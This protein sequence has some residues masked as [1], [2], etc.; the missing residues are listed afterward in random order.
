MDAFASL[1]FRPKVELLVKEGHDAFLSRRALAFADGNLEDARAILV[2]DEMDAEREK[3]EEEAKSKESPASP[4]VDDDVLAQLRKEKEEKQKEEK[5]QPP[6]SEFKTVSVN[7]DFDPTAGGISQPAPAPQNPGGVPPPA[8]KS[9]VVFE[10]TAAQI[11]ELV[12]ESPVP[13]LVDVYADWCGPCKHLTPL[14]EEMAVKAGGAFRLVK[15]NTDNE[16]AVSGALEVKALPTVFAVRNGRVL[17][18]FEGMP[19]S[20]EMMKGF[21]MGLL[22]E[23]ADFTPPLSADDKKRYAELTSK[24]VKTAG[25]ASFTFAARERLQD[26]MSK[27][28]QELVKAYD[29]NMLDA[30]DSANTLR[31]LFSNVIRKPDDAKYRRVNLQNKVIAAKI[32][33]F[34]P[35]ISMLKYVG[36]VK[37]ADGSAM[38]IGK[39]KKVVNVAPLTVARDAIDKWIDRNRHTLAAAARKRKDEKERARLAAEAA[40]NPPE[41][42]DED[43]EVEVDPDAVTLKVRLEGKKKVHELALHADDPLQA[44]LDAL[45]I[46][47]DQ[48]GVQIVCASK[49]LV[50]KASDAGAMAKTLREHK[51]V[52]AA[53]LVIKLGNVVEREASSS[54]KDRASAQKSKKKGSHTMQSVGIYAKDDN[55]K[56]ELIDGGGGTLFE[57]DVTDSEDEGESVEMEEADDDQEDDEE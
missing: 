23:G 33:A 15:V 30:E 32:A 43:E 16:R 17:N 55:A 28:L 21:M 39:G 49:K 6:K 47:V 7:A 11:Q 24:L 18:N 2:A 5:K 38:T 50:V 52:P 54:L 22:M 27:Q 14:L 42:E 53:S 41:E 35:C 57:H 3:E 45:P 48:D 20:E 8:K 46:E 13:V 44:A 26:R 56:G 51:L 9:D 25:A 1:L 19:R 40:L 31:S 10:A 12:L 4:S 36:F 29:G 34:P 37:E